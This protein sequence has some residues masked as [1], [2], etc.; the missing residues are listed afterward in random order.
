[1]DVALRL[2][3]DWP[4]VWFDVAIAFQQRGRSREANV[5]LEKGLA[6]DQTSWRSLLATG[7]AELAEEHWSAAVAKFKKCLQEN[8][9]CLPAMEKLGL[10][11]LK[12]GDLNPARENY[13]AFLD[14]ETDE[15]NCRA[16]RQVLSYINERLVFSLEPQRSLDRP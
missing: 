11:L 10:A 7:L 5:F 9:E 1:M 4:R 13:R 15:G 14:R 6:L 12:Q 16:A 8:P 3:P 2:V